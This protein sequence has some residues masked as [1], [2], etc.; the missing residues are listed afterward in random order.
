MAQ[1]H[2]HVTIVVNGEQHQWPKTDIGYEDVAKLAFQGAFDP[3]IVYSIKFRNG[4][5]EKPE[6]NLVKGGSVKVKEGMIFTAK[7]TG[8]S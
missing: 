5:G 8:E 3:N 6:G 4:H 1:E 2:K 7:D